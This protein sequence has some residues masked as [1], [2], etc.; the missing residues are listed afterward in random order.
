LGR[1]ATVGRR[2]RAPAHHYPHRT[3]PGH[4]I[5]CPRGWSRPWHR[6]PHRQCPPTCRAPWGW[7]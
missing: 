1:P 7:L 6:D 4:T 3:L 5:Q 2:E